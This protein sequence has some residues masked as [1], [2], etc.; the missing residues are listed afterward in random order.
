MT[1]IRTEVITIDGTQLKAK[2][3]YFT[4]ADLENLRTVYTSFMSLR[5]TIKNFG[6]KNHRGPNIPETLTEGA[7]AFFHGSPRLYSLSG[8]SS[9]SFDNFDVRTNERIQVKAMSAAGPTSFG[10]KSVFD[11]LYFLDFLR[12]GSMDGK[13]DVYDIPLNLVYDVNV[14]RNQTVADQQLQAR[15]PRL[16]MFQ[17][18]ITPNGLEPMIT[19]DIMEA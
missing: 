12:D 7:F 8:K 11:K 1:E 15:R 17:D 5:N 18:V 4:D 16:G 13:F 6:D 14:N 10:P 19:Y 3:E 9:A 2:L